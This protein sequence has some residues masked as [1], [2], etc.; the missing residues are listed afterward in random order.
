[1]KK[2]DDM[3]WWEV[4]AVLTFL[5]LVFLV[6]PGVLVGI[7]IAAWRHGDYGLALLN[8][9]V[10]LDC[11]FSALYAPRSKDASWLWYLPGSG[12]FALLYRRDKKNAPGI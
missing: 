9:F 5:A 6:A 11:L 8:V 7:A 3:Q 12:F 2:I 1:V 10:V 4:V